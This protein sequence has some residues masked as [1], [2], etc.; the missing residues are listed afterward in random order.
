M[1]ADNEYVTHNDTLGYEYGF[2]SFDQM[3]ITMFNC[4]EVR[5]WCPSGFGRV[6]YDKIQSFM[7]IRDPK[8]TLIPDT[9]K[10]LSNDKDSSIT[11]V[12]PN[13]SNLISRS[14]RKH[15]MNEITN[16]DDVT[17]HAVQGR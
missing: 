12:L 10:I 3:E 6:L 15:S 17:P 2:S 8:R 7:R 5:F 4:H 11:F 16:D 1:L 14:L 13:T 9:S